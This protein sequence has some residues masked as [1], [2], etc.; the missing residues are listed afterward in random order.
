MLK[1]AKKCQRFVVSSG[2]FQ[3]LK[4]WELLACLKLSVGLYCLLKNK[5][6]FFVEGLNLSR[7]L[8]INRL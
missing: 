6:V 2:S 1:L 4:W 7:H 3:W 8:E 5:F